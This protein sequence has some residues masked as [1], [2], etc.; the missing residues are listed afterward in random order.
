MGGYR[1]N[2][3]DCAIIAQIL[4]LRSADEKY[5][6]SIYTGP[7]FTK[8]RIKEYFP[9]TLKFFKWDESTGQYHAEFSGVKG[10]RNYIARA[11]TFA[12]EYEQLPWGK[13]KICHSIIPPFD[14]GVV[15]L[16]DKMDL[17]KDASAVICQLVDVARQELE[18]AKS[19]IISGIRGLGYGNTADEYNN[20][21]NKIEECLKSKH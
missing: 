20:L 3:C 6:T 17:N 21:A 14:D 7:F 16:C 12:S 2:L 10:L 5:S 19:D 15:S 8:D 4:L 11:K 18:L 1:E 9:E 13:K